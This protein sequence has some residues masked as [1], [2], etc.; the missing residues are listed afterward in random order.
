ML[1]KTFVDVFYHTF[2][3][4]SILSFWICCNA[5]GLS[6]SQPGKWD[7]V[8]IPRQD[9]R[10][11]KSTNDDSDLIIFCVYLCEEKLAGTVQLRP[12]GGGG[13]NG[14]Q[15][16]LHMCKVWENVKEHFFTIVKCEWEPSHR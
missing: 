12:G 8:I 4:A 16:G 13:E 3:S 14:E 15:E 7:T 10:P 1:S 2:I 6:G 5:T 11:K 9:F